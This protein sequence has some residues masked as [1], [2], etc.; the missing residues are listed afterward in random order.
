MTNTNAKPHYIVKIRTD[1]KSPTNK[2][3]GYYT[4]GAAWQ[5]DDDSIVLDINFPVPFLID[6]KTK[7]IL[8]PNN[9]DYPVQEEE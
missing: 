1:E 5:R 3:Y 2:K 7:V 9:K 8:F 4:I 6:D